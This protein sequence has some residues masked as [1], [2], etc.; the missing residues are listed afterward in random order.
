MRPLN[1]LAMTLK[2]ELLGVDLDCS[3]LLMALAPV[4]SWKLTQS[5]MHIIGFFK[6]NLADLFSICHVFFV[7]QKRLKQF[8]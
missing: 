7:R 1:R 4:E 2:S 3:K 6:A 5:N 8:V